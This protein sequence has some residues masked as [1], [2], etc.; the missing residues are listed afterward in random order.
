MTDSIIRLMDLV[1]IPDLYS[2]W[3]VLCERLLS[4]YIPVILSGILIILMRYQW[5]YFNPTKVNL[6]WILFIGLFIVKKDI[7]GKGIGKTTR[8]KT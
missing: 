7:R 2:P 3:V 6:N 4:V 8:T 5:M 1:M